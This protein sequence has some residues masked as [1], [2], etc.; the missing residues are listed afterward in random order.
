M[1]DVNT[2]DDLDIIRETIDLECKLAGGR[3]GKGALPEDFWRTYS[4]FANTQGG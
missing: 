2:L 1:I 4:A 3:D